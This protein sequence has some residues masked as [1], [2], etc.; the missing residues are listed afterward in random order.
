MGWT[1]DR[2]RLAA[3][4]HLV[5]RSSISSARPMSGPGAKVLMEVMHT[6][7]GFAIVPH[8]RA[9]RQG[10]CRWRCPS[11]SATGPNLM[12]TRSSSGRGRR[13][14]WSSSPTR[15]NPTATFPAGMAELQRAGPRGLPAECL[16]GRCDGALCGIRRGYDG[17][18]GLVEA[19]NDVVMTRTF[20]K[21]PTGWGVL[22]VGYGYAPAAR[23]GYAEPHPGALQPVGRRAGGGRG[24]RCGT[25]AGWPSAC[26]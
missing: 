23:G 18:K 10:Q 6:E 19:R 1:P 2:T 4:G 22:R 24:R 7:H 14:G 20:S 15:A 13:R 17:G 16:L 25:W 26:A 9:G 11:A 5:T 8:Q 3:W 12:S 21:R